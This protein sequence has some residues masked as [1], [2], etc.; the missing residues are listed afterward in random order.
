MNFLHPLFLYRNNFTCIKQVILLFRIRIN[1]CS[2]NNRLR[3]LNLFL[4]LFRLYWILRVLNYGKFEKKRGRT[5]YI[6]FYF[7]CLYDSRSC[8][9]DRISG[10]MRTGSER[11]K[12]SVRGKIVCFF[13]GRRKEAAFPGT[14]CASEYD[15]TARLFPP[16]GKCSMETKGGSRNW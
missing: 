10:G 14:E 11:E 8:G 5:G 3:F 12:E 15:L 13:C 9:M 2:E 4:Y 7:V 6:L 16:S 1:V